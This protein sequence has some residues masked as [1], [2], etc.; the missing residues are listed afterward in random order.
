MNEGAHSVFR[1]ESKDLNELAFECL[2]GSLMFTTLKAH[3]FLL[4]GF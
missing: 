1:A 2:E 4:G 3:W